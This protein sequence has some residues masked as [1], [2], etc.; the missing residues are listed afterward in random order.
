MNEFSLSIIVPCYNEADNIFPL[1][2]RIQEVM[3]PYNNYEIILVNDGSCDNTQQ[4]IESAL[5]EDESIKYICFSRNFGHQ[6]ALK[7]GI[8]FAH[9]DCIVT[10][11]ADLQHPPETILKMI[12]LWQK[13]YDIVTAIGADKNRSSLL[14]RQ[15]SKWYYLFLS[16]ISDQDVM[17]NGADFRLIDRKVGDIIRNIPGQNIYL[18]GLFSWI[19]FKQTTIKYQEENRIHGTTKYTF[20]KM[21]SLASNG[22]TSSSIKPLRFAL[23]AGIFFALLA[24]GYGMYAV[25]VMLMGLTIVGW[26]SIVACIVFLSGIQLIVLGVM[27][28][29]LGKL[30]MESKQRPSYFIT[31]TNINNIDRRN[32]HQKERRGAMS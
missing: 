25:I 19:G 8:D 15:T 12:T 5:H 24:F 28:E 9:G 1:L 11:D 4:V 29:Y 27:G 18:R 7:A 14:K 20:K 30:Y 26:T 3:Q 2:S 23:S 10:M 22:I 21:L 31:K 17:I 16:K 6:T 13:G 32:N